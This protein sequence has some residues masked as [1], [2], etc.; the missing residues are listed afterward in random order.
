MNRNAGVDPDVAQQVFET[1]Q[2][3]VH[4]NE[5]LKNNHVFV[6]MGASVTDT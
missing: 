5:D 6:V 4:L 3:V 2:T 1:F